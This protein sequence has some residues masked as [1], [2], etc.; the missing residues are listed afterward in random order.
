MDLDHIKGSWKAGEKCLD[1]ALGMGSNKEPLYVL[2]QECNV[3]MSVLE[4]DSDWLVTISYVIKSGNL[5]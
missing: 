1:L 4:K 3:M 2:E 5:V